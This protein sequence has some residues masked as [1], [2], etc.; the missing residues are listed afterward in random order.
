MPI[1][2]GTLK[3]GAGQP[4]AGC[5]IQLK[6]MNT[7]SAVIR[8]TTARV[9]ANAGA[10]S[11]DAQP[12]RYEVTLAV[13]DYPPHKVGV[14][15][16]YADSPDGTLNDFLTA[17]KAE[18]LTPD[19]MNQFKL[20]AQQSR[21]AAEAA[22]V[23]S[24]GVSTIKDAAEKAASNAALSE[25]NA[26]GSVTKTAA[27][28]AAALVSQNAAKTSEDA[29]SASAVKA[30]V[31]EANAYYSA[32]AA[33]A[34]QN[35]AK[36][37]EIAAAL[38]AT[39]AGNHEA[40]AFSN[41]NAARRSGEVAN[42]AATVTTAAK[43]AAV[44]QVTGFDAHVS[45]Q[46]SVI[47]QAVDSATTKA[48][49]DI[50]AATDIN[51][52]N[53]IQAINQKQAEATS[54]IQAGMDA[55]A[56]SANSAGES[57]QSALTYKN[58][59]LGFASDAATIARQIKASQDTAKLSEANA[60]TYSSNAATS[61]AAAKASEDAAGVNKTATELARS[62]A[63]A[64]LEEAR[65]IAKTPGPV[66]PQGLPGVQGP[67]G[68][69]GLK[70]DTGPAGPR[71]L[72]GPT[73][74]QGLQGI[75]GI[76]GPKGDTGL[77]LQGPAGP[78]GATGPRGL[79]GLTGPAGAPGP[80][81]DIGPVGP[82]GFTG[83]AGPAGPSGPV[84]PQGPR[85]FTGP[86]GPAGPA[87]SVSGTVYGDLTVTGNTYVND[88]YIRSDRRSKRNFRTMGDAL[89]KVDKL[90]GQLYEVQAGGRFVRSGGLIAQDVQAVLP[91]LVTADKDSGLLRLNYNGVTGLLVE[92][93]KELRA[94]LRK[95]RG[96]A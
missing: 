11:I 22:G 43:D 5:T 58:S 25:I 41:A 55:A 75:A 96:A 31:S 70:G 23:A 57:A 87:G 56:L 60:A 26:A 12:G 81:G 84:G 73:G 62:A 76:Q 48:N 95:L 30:S 4:I 28:S 88:T 50:A 18:Y 40:T 77:G 65:L 42:Y 61:A 1:I 7:T 6:A 71:G 93:V 3:D 45:Q 19:V 35:A 8:S 51:R 29:A 79:T 16:V 78:A 47:T 10:Y 38:S 67:Q 27:S 9:G 49:A 92:A 15:D 39:T 37:S 17:T 46:K 68:I 85:G 64:A 89:D 63:Q 83:P 94:E 72:T 36:Q 21:E 53:A 32:A 34:S 90:N 2:S 69:Q 91:D 24:Q 54:A 59:A 80:K 44:A 20:L 86:A 74:P 66:G 52:N 14:I 82:Q 13:E 33:L